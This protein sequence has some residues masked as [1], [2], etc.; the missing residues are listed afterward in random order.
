[1]EF[2]EYMARQRPALMRFATV[3]TG[4]AWLADDLVSDVLCRA[5]ERWDRI[6]RMAEPNAYVRRMIVNDY[7]S[8]R[9]RLARTAPRAEV[10]PAAPGLGDGTDEHAER[11]AMIRR[12]AGLPRRQRAAVVLRYYLGLPDADIADHLGCRVTTVRSQISR[13]LATLRIDLTADR[14][15]QETR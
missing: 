1:M 10:E 14:T 12:L 15:Y 13:A 5:F 4:Q 6:S 9:R 7:L 8:W 3:L 2:G 11:D